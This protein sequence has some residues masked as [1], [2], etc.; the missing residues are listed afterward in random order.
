MF[1]QRGS[2][3]VAML[4]C[5]LLSLLLP[6]IGAADDFDRFQLYAECRP[7]ELVVHVNA[8]TKESVSEATRI[9]YA[10]ARQ[11]LDANRMFTSDPA[12]AG[13][14]LVITV[15]DYYGAHSITLD[16]YKLV[17]DV[18]SDS[19]YGAITWQHGGVGYYPGKWREF[20][21]FI[22]LQIS[23]HLDAFIAKY[24]RANEAACGH[25]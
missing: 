13:S 7:I 24:R 4:R 22:L 6:M 2:D 16:Y 20:I 11:R 19:T 25:S 17:R 21:D 23:R 14:R 1:W 18:Y 10:A 3:G 12:Q 5:V 15:S 8:E 9:I